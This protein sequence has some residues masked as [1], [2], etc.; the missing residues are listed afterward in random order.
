[1]DA[2]YNLSYKNIKIVIVDNASKDVA[3]LESHPNSSVH[4]FRS[5]INTGWAGGCNI[6]A[7]FAIELG[8]EFIWFL[9]N[10]SQPEIDALDEL[11]SCFNSGGYRI[12]A[13]GSI[14]DNGS[15]GDDFPVCEYDSKNEFIGPSVSIRDLVEGAF[16][17]VRTGYVSGCSM[18]VSVDAWAHI[19]G[20]DESLFLY[21]E[22]VDW[23]VRCNKKGY[24]I[25]YRTKSIVFHKGGASTGGN[26]RPL[27]SYF[28]SRNHLVISAKHRGLKKI[29][30]ALRYNYWMACAAS[31]EEGFSSLWV[32]VIYSL[33]VRA[34]VVGVIHFFLMRRGDSG[35]YIRKIH[36]MSKII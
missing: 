35:N 8:C 6:G 23:G 4:L 2:I 11:M 22:D 16:G 14:E 3:G 21:C 33:R 34:I 1:L 5:S 10:D 15:R 27:Q 26:K 36:S 25:G 18:L 7:R 9:N 12:G 24:L 17:L 30:S 32:G 29:P 19:G 13:V 28:A 20:F 31:S